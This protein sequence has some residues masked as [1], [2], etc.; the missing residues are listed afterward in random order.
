MGQIRQEFCKLR[1]RRSKRGGCAFGKRRQVLL[2]KR[3]F[4]RRVRCC[5]GSCNRSSCHD[6]LSRCCRPEC[7]NMASHCFGMHRIDPTGTLN[8]IQPLITP[9]HPPRFQRGCQRRFDPIECLNRL[10]NTGSKRTPI[11]RILSRSSNI[12]TR[13]FMV[14]PHQITLRAHHRRRRDEI[15]GGRI[16]RLRLSSCLTHPR[17]ILRTRTTNSHH[18]PQARKHP[19]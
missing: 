16:D 6:L 1:H 12:R 4:R 10:R 18:R 7:F 11:R 5:C 2:L 19:S 8:P 14:Q 9:T 17:R 15:R 13:K 3:C